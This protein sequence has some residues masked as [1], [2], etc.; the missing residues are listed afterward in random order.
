MAS[1]SSIS[2]NL[3]P[4]KLKTI[5]AFEKLEETKLNFEIY[6]DR[7]K[8]LGIDEDLLETLLDN[9]KSL[10]IDTI[11]VN[12]IILLTPIKEKLTGTMD[13]E[14]KKKIMV[15]LVKYC[16]NLNIIFT[17]IKKSVILLCK[18]HYKLENPNCKQP[19]LT[20][21]YEDNIQSHEGGGK[22]EKQIR[23]INKQNR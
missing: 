20:K 22:N 19:N 7:L 1:A 18:F 2:P 10:T 16:K 6:I 15:N 5:Y 14:N 3:G 4:Q 13:L 23:I 9:I 11:N 12:Y 21:F 8:A 17:Y